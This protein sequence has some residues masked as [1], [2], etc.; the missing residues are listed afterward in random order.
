M[1]DDD[2]IATA[3]GSAARILVPMARMYL[4]PA[5]SIALRDEA[6]ASTAHDLEAAER[7]IL[8]L[9]LNKLVIEAG[10][11][12]APGTAY[13][14]HTT[15]FTIDPQTRMGT[16][17]DLPFVVAAM[18][19]LAAWAGAGPD[20]ATGDKVSTANAANPEAEPSKASNPP[21]TTRDLRMS[22]RTRGYANAASPTAASATPAASSRRAGGCGCR[23][24]STAIAPGVA[25][26]RAPRR[27]TRKP[28]CQDPR[29][30]CDCGL[31]CGGN[32]CG[33]SGKTSC[34]DCIPRGAPAGDACSCGTCTPP[35]PEAC[36]PWTPS[37]TTRNRLRACLKDILCDV[38]L[39]VE[40]ALCSGGK[41][42]AE[43]LRKCF[44]DLFCRLLKCIREALC[45]PPAVRT[46]V[47]P[48]IP[49]DCLPCS[50]AVEDPR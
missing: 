18:R 17:L 3:I 10:A 47:L 40:Q 11:V 34:T 28:E 19:G 46:P 30:H 42:D 14:P 49:N 36:T 44:T 35:P 12:P 41:L 20:H 39:C 16:A 48:P 21:T 13:A 1:R 23:G 31:T 6:G 22:A 33:C 38:L 4:G 24:G 9:A 32:G 50:Y 26:P 15:V 25:A 7:R 2:A 43:A 27:I 45:P 29:P 5:V 37:C 8:M